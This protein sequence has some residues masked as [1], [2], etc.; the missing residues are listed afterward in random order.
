MKALNVG[1]GP[2]LFPAPWVN[3]DMLPDI[4]ADVVMNAED[5]W[6][7]E[8]DTFD[9]VLANHVAEHCLDKFHFI[10]E[11]WRVSKCGAFVQI[12]LPIHT[13][14]NFWDDPTHKS[15]WTP[16][17]LDCFLQGN[18]AHTALGFRD[19]EFI[20]HRFEIRDGWEL[21]WDLEVVKPRIPACAAPPIPIP[22][23]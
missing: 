17:S 23:I 3:S 18:G 5:A 8:N 20:Q 22:V 16:R 13:W 19:I 12:N 6:P 15:F 10:K 9:Q 11:L 7:W 14:E 4:G 21:S 1:C 2:R